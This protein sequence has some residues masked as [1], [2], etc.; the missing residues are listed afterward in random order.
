MTLEKFM[1]ILRSE[2]AVVRVVGLTMERQ[3][4]KVSVG[5]K[6]VEA[7]PSASDSEVH[8]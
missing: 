8:C 2:V 1:S 3:W 6:G 5:I 7:L 4:F